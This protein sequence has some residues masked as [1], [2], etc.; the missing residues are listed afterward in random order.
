MKL[1]TLSLICF[2]CQLIYPQQQI[3]ELKLDVNYSNIEVGHLID[4][5]SVKYQIEFSY[6]SK[7]VPLDSIVFINRKNVT[8][9]EILYDVLGSE[10]L[11]ISYF[12]DQIVIS[13][14]PYL[15][16]NSIQ[17]NLLINGIVLNN[18]SYEPLPFVNISILNE[19]IGSI[20]N[21]KGEFSFYIPPKYCSDSIRFSSIGFSAKAIKVP[22]QDSTV[23][24]L[25]EEENIR[26]PEVQVTALPALEIMRKVIRKES[27]NYFNT[28]VA[29]TGFFR[30]VIKQDNNIV[31]ASE[32]LIDIYK[33]SYQNSV[34]LEKVKFIKGRK[35]SDVDSMQSIAF[36]LQGGP[37]I[38]SRL[39]IVRY[40]DFF[41]DNNVEDIY[42]Y[43][44]NGVRYIDDKKVYLIGFK[45]YDDTGE[46]LYEGEFSINAEDFALISVEFQ[47]TK[48]TLKKSRKYLIKKDN[49]HSR[50][51]P[52]FARYYLDYRQYRNKWMLNRVSGEIKV[53][54]IG[55]KNKI[56]S[57]FFAKTEMVITDLRPVDEERI[58]NSETYKPNEILYD[59]VQKSDPEFWEYYN[60]IKPED[61]ISKVFNKE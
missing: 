17:E 46:L 40:H 25:L 26:L 30:E 29:L 58:K 54:V 45:P 34:A 55:T 1:L 33:P 9:K 20:T 52:Y 8:L 44:Y 43:T 18:K 56:R 49:R 10:D 61:D 22:E 35:R 28:P 47:M 24:V 42:K 53:R 7:A 19:P 5:L 48:N 2:I 11:D 32:A 36:R 13:R 50:A 39:D 51:K 41:P 59:E 37:Y 15:D 12:N 38:F 60:I 23:K 31:Q 3:P 14:N 6:D 16:K 57:D 27:D 21:D 4:S